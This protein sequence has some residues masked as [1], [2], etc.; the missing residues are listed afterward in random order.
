MVKIDIKP[1][2]VNIGFVFP[3]LGEVNVFRQREDAKEIVK[4]K[5]F[6]DKYGAPQIDELNPRKYGSK[7]SFCKE[8]LADYVI[9]E[10]KGDL[11]QVFHIDECCL[12][13][14]RS[15]LCWHGNKSHSISRN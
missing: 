3:D 14:Y 12:G 7:C 9:F 11:L 6:F 10:K 8:G 15:I 5:I 4:E 13:K 1:V 2:K